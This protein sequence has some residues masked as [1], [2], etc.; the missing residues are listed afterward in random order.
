M[1]SLYVKAKSKKAI[2]ESLA[3][4][5]EVYGDHYTLE[6][7][8]NVWLDEKLPSGTVIKVYEKTVGGSPYAKAYGTWDAKKNRVK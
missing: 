1:I 8:R 6:G 5:F 4:G 2:N 3:S 7:G